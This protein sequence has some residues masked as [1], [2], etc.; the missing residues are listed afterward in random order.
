[1]PP[2]QLVDSYDDADALW[3]AVLELR[4]EGVV[5][6]RHH[7]RYRP[8]ERLWVRQKSS[9]WARCDEEREVAI[10]RRTLAV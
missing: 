2:C 1:M 6:K 8:G 3:D 5:A 4:L 7:E 9:R 10:R